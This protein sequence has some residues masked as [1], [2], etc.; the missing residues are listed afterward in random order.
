MSNLPRISEE[1][2]YGFSGLFRQAAEGGNQVSQAASAVKGF[3][4]GFWNLDE[5]HEE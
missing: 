2:G 3:L 5:L 4:A 1:A